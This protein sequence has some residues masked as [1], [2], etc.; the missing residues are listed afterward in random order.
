MQKNVDLPK[1]T[2]PSAAICLRFKTSQW[3]RWTWT[4]ERLT[5][6]RSTRREF[7]SSEWMQT[8]STS[9]H[10]D[11]SIVLIIMGSWRGPE[12]SHHQQTP[13]HP[14][15]LN[16][17]IEAGSLLSAKAPNQNYQ[18]PIVASVPGKKKRTYSYWAKNCSQVNEGAMHSLMKWTFLHESLQYVLFLVAQ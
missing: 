18:A 7:V 13:W 11:L 17:L 16:M 8:W 15:S 12:A 9:S 3:L 5:P 6:S 10:F 4:N 1:A 14:T 2:Q